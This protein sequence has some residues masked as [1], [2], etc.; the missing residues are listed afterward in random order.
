MIEAISAGLARD[1]RADEGCVAHAYQCSEGYWTI[2]VGRLIDARRGGRLSED[3]IA[4]LLKNDIARCVADVATLPAWA[5]V[6]DD[7]VRARGLLNMRFQLGAA[8]LR[9]FANTLKRIAA[10]DWD[11]AAAGLRGSKWARQTPGRAARVI[12][13]IETGKERV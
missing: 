6:K 8:G 10:R 9:S 12:A 11:D 3:E 7:P 5:A 2:G 13:M 1:L 4:L